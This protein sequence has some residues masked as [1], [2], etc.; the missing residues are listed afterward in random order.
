MPFRIVKVDGGFKVVDDMGRQYSRKPLTKYMARQQQKAL[1][2]SEARGGI[3]YGSGYQVIDGH[4]L[5]EGAGFFSDV[6]KVAKRITRTATAPIRAVVQRVGDVARG[7][8][9]G[10]PPNVRSVIGD[11]G[12]GTVANII[13]RREPIMSFVDKALNVISFGKW[14]K[15]KDELNYDKLYH[16]SMVVS[17]TMPDGLE[18]A[19]MME[20]NEVINITP[21]FSMSPKMDFVRV[22]VSQQLTLKEML[23]NTQGFMGAD[24][25]TYDPFKNNCQRFIDSVLT[26]NSLNTPN[27]HAFIV[28]PV[29]ELLKRLPGYTGKVA[30]AI[31]D[32]AAVAD[33]ALK[34]RS[35]YANKKRGG[36]ATREWF[37][38]QKSLGRLK[39]YA[40]FE[41]MVGQQKAATESAAARTKELADK[42][43][44]DPDSL[45]KMCNI[46]E[47][48]TPG[49]NLTTVGRC[50]ELHRLNI[51][52]VKR[53]VE[54]ARRRN[55][56]KRNSFFGKVVQG[57]TDVA[58]FVVDAIPGVNTVA[59]E[60]YKT[61]APPTS[62]FYKG[63]K[64]RGGVATKAWFDK[65]KAMGRLK[66]YATY[67]DMVGQQKA[68]QQQAARNAAETAATEDARRAMLQPGEELVACKVKD[69]LSLGRNVV[70]KQRCKELHDARFAKWEAENHPVSAKFFR[71]IVEGL[72]KAAD[73]AVGNIPGINTIAKEAYKT[74]APPGSQYYQPGTVAEK[75]TRAVL[76]QGK[77]WIK[78]VKLKEGAF[79]KQAL[80][81]KMTPMEF[82]KYVLSHPDKF[83]LTTRR[84]AQFL[85]NIQGNGRPDIK[86]P[87]KDFLAEHKKLLSVLSEPT[88]AKLKA[89]YMDQSSELQKVLKGKGCGCGCD[90]GMKP[91]ASW[92]NIVKRV[93]EKAGYNPDDIRKASGDKKLTIKTPDGREVSFGAAGAGDY[94]IYS[95][96]E[97]EGKVP[98]GTAEKHR[99]AYL[100]RAKKIK[101]NWKKDKFSPNNLAIKILWV[102]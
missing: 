51:E 101:G 47:A 99:A 41:D 42:A 54:D 50:K 21:N 40:S 7:V 66:Q 85:K 15:A 57:L 32:V 36:A 81:R 49:K 2:A 80:A 20:K 43:A 3:Y 9:G 29:E 71:P 46:T 31:T 55:E 77:N 87:F 38:R 1:Y 53:K 88:P 39:Q 79:T 94:I 65:Q 10:Y 62:K 14:N 98:A 25:F 30:R 56:E 11:Y 5:L 78:D 17:L 33:V 24:Y 70:S 48:L 93:A 64:K 13:V 18:R 52:D 97:R 44:A 75:A 92:F 82:M 23:D 69:D 83:Q 73:F 22:P 89:E 6:W 59:K 4:L 8:R 74:F 90:G 27:A 16:L 96:L 86:I 45:P 12:V 91:P 63:G 68:A 28:Q 26:A 102:D 35:M 61:F 60:V 58:D 95:L 72:T 84:R 34:G 100:A 67:E 19:V 37:N 76:G